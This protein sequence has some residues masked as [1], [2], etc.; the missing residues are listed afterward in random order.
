[1]AKGSDFNVKTSP[2]E[3]AF[4]EPNTF[5]LGVRMRLLA[6]NGLKSPTMKKPLGKV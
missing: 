1:M 4:G 6:K 3:P 2:Q 5:L